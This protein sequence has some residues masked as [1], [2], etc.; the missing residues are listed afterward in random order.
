MHTA[1]H[2]GQITLNTF[3]MIFYFFLQVHVQKND[4]A[5]HWVCH[6]K[7]C[8]TDFKEDIKKAYRNPERLRSHIKKHCQ[9]A[10]KVR[11]Y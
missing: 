6:W 11:L 8:A 4:A 1:I 2:F 3:T 10:E 5:D 9:E 7:G